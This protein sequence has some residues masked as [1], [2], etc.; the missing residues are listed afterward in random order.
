ML[1]AGEPAAQ[2]G[3]HQ[4]AA[5]VDACKHTSACAGRVL[6]WTATCELPRQGSNPL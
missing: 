5:L 3:L 2:M 1:R 6:W 4:L